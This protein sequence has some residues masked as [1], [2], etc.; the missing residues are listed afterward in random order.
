MPYRFVRATSIV[1]IVFLAAACAPQLSPRQELTWDAFKSCESE[2]PSARLDRVDVDGGWGLRGREGEVFKVSR[3]M[4]AYWNRAMLEG[5]LPA[6][7]PSL[8]VTPAPSRP[9]AFVVPEP[10]IWSTGDSWD[11]VSTSTAGGRRTFTW[12][13]DREETVEGVTY[14]VLKSGT[15]ESFYRKSDLAYS[16]ENRRSSLAT[17]NTPPRLYY[18]WPLSVG[19]GWEQTYRHERL[20]DKQAYD[21]GYA[22]AV[23]AEE[24]VTVPA[25]AFQTLKIVYRDRAKK[26]VLWEQWY[27]PKVR[28]WVRL[29]DQRE[30]GV[31]T[32]DL[33]KFTLDGKV[34]QA[35]QSHVRAA[36]V[37]DSS[38]SSSSR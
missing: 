33:V 12:R 3:C 27:S 14:Y 19:A 5:R 4:S 20:E 17:R 16:H 18:V 23:E 2:G 38:T 10:P 28:H 13:V 6:G 24:V 11:F 9:H 15:V 36:S 35:S 26:T 1:S 31:R 25:G 29:R 37:T 32:Q 30:E 21:T 34:A 8:A 22:A 7:A